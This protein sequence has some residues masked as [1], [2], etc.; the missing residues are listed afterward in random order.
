MRSSIQ[1]ELQHINDTSRNI[2]ARIIRLQ[3]SPPSQENS[4]EQAKPESNIL[5][6]LLSTR[7][8]RIKQLFTHYSLDELSIEVELIN[9]MMKLDSQLQAQAHQCK[10]IL[11]EQVIKLKNSKKIKDL[12]QNF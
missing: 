1:K 11:T 8:E 6:E 3:K 7:D 12:Y 9:E 10:N 4:S 5:V 2:L